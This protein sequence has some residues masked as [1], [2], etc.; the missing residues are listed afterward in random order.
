MR[1][2]W[3]E[4]LTTLV[5]DAGEKESALLLS[6]TFICI[7]LV[8]TFFKMR[9]YPFGDYTLLFADGWQYAAF[10][11][12]VA[13]NVREGESL[14]YSFRMVA[15]GGLLPTIAYY[16]ASP[17]NLLFL[18]FGHN[19]VAGIHAVAA[20][21]YV[22]ASLTFCIL[23][24]ARTEK[25][26]ALSGRNIA[27]LPS[28]LMRASFSTGYAFIS[29]MVFFAWNLSW[30]DGVIVLPLMTLGIIR[31][32]EEKKSMLYLISLAYALIS[33]YY[34]G[35]MLCIASVLIYVFYHFFHA[36]EITQLK[37][38]LKESLARYIVSSVTGA[39]LSA[40]LVLPALLNLPED[41]MR[42][43]D[44]A[45]GSMR[46]IF[47]FTRFFSGLFTGR[48]DIQSD[49]LP[50]I[51]C[52]VI[53]V[54]LIVCYFFDKSVSLYKKIVVMALGGV[55][56]LSFW[57][58]AVN[59]IWHGMSVNAWFNYRYSFLISFLMLYFAY[60]SL[61]RVR[62]RSVPFRH[63]TVAVAVFFAWVVNDTMGFFYAKE[64]MYDVLQIALGILVLK[65]ITSRQEH[66]TRERTLPYALISLLMLAGCYLNTVAV[67]SQD[68]RASHL[69]SSFLQTTETRK[70]AVANVKEMSAEP[71]FRMDFVSFH[72]RN[73]PFLLKYDGLSNYASTENAPVLRAMRDFGLQ[74]DWFYANYGAHVPY[75]ADVL[76]GMRYLLSTAPLP[77]K[78]LE[79]AGMT[80]GF[81]ILENKHALPLLFLSDEAADTTGLTDPFTRTNIVFQALS[82]AGEGDV[83][84][85][86]HPALS[87]EEDGS[88][89]LVISGTEHRG[90]PLY[91]HLPEGLETVTLYADA[92]PNVYPAQGV[93]QVLPV[94]TQESVIDLT[95]RGFSAEL[96]YEESQRLYYIGTFPVG[97]GVELV[98]CPK[99][100]D[101]EATV[102]ITAQVAAL[103]TAAVDAVAEKVLS[104]APYIS[105]QGDADIT[106]E[107]QAPRDMYLSSTI[108][109]D[110]AWRI[111]VD[112][113]EV[114]PERFMEVFLAVPLA[115]GAHMV[116]LTYHP[117][118]LFPGS[119]LTLLALLVTIVIVVRERKKGVN[120]ETYA[121]E[122]A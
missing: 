55:F 28:V 82:A 104:Q 2:K 102:P 46:G 49:N 63:M 117:R 99:E 45:Y 73:D 110:E 50:L 97:C 16:A 35:Y 101:E 80:Q 54:L 94:V 84:T 65:H 113:A 109:Y 90:A 115:Q 20:V 52:G 70:Q 114:M 89:R 87:A 111:T 36:T 25:I 39:A 121:K 14:L 120:D 103:E 51:Y 9:I 32:I 75:T 119:L 67:M 71:F 78:P 17:F 53:P 13:D 5:E 33:N 96:P 6:G 61:H 19:I 56:F 38:S 34:I 68:V 42:T 4:R 30:M 108:P 76:F 44:E 95:G 74:Q 10:Y 27:L 69:A 92:E 26:A 7:L 18:F 41:R 72:T 21:K 37:T 107:V 81:S 40:F 122:T 47:N 57:N 60:I 59:T 15:G 8:L 118:G 105:M 58:S 22:S 11:R 88:V 100:E 1:E 3:N 12:T 48:T 79:D 98:L 83:Y 85:L 77:Q 23:L 66:E 86:M 24:N 116:H 29:Y 64:I 106:A 112:G 93:E 62:G 31:L 91:A 43:A